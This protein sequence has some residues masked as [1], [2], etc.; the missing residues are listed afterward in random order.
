MGTIACNDFF[1]DRDRRP[2]ARR[3][4]TTPPAPAAPAATSAS[5]GSATSPSA[6]ATAAS[7]AAL[8]GAGQPC[9]QGRFC[10]PRSALLERPAPARRRASWTPTCDAS[11]PCRYT[12][13]CNGGHLPRA[14]GRPAPS[15]R[16]RRLRRVQRR[17]SATPT[18]ACASAHAWAPPCGPP[19]TA[20]PSPSAPP[21][22]PATAGTCQP[23]AADGA[24]CDDNN[25]PFCM[26]PASCLGGTCQLPRLRRELRARGCGQQHAAVGPARGPGGGCAR[27]AAERA[28]RAAGLPDPARA[29]PAKASAAAGRDRHAHQQLRDR[30]ADRRG[31]HGHRLPGPPP[32]HRPQGAPSRCCTR[33][34]PATAAWSPASSTRP[35]RPTPSATPTSST[36]STSGMLPGTERPYLM[37][38]FLEGESLATRL[39]RVGRLPVA[40]AAR[41]R[42]PDRLGAGGGARQGD[43]PPRPQARE[44]VPGPARLAARARAGQGARLRHRQA[45][46]RDRRRPGADPDRHADGHAAVHVARAV[47]G[48]DQRRSI[49]APTSTRWGSSCTRW[50]AAARPSSADGLRRPAGHAHH[51]GA[52][53][54]PRAQPRRARGARGHHPQGAGQGCRRA[55]RQH[56]RLRG[57][58]GDRPACP[59]GTL[60]GMGPP[61][62]APPSAPPPPAR[63][64]SPRRA[65]PDHHHL[66]GLGRARC[67]PTWRRWRC[68]RSRRPLLFG[69][70]ALAVAA[71]AVCAR[72]ARRAIAGPG[73]RPRPPA[74]RRRAAGPGQSTPAQPRSQPRSGTADRGDRTPPSPRRPSHPDA[75]AAPRPPASRPGRKPTTPKPAGTRPARAGPEKW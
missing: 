35:A 22:A 24:A 6:R 27:W 45:A 60:E 53:R 3:P 12:L 31:R 73:S 5:P 63:P 30:L 57:G 74:D 42:P 62:R 14:R 32:A 16:P 58:P 1:D 13:V 26:T 65:R 47:P 17:R 10:A 34:W 38:E 68:V 69:G 71:G 59:A 43:R 41:H 64:R 7:A 9:H 52:A 67:R 46:R 61:W 21:P 19:R 2:P 25:G 18:P 33:S 55:L 72:D 51:A 66:P 39:A 36:S 56:G 75:G 48:A 4:G 50:S 8:P 11:K 54:P 44:P 20:R 28:G 49:S 15:A 23:A 70:A 40:E 29:L 37:M